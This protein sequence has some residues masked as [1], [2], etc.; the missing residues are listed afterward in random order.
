M[1]VARASHRLS[2][3]TSHN[4]HRFS[5]AEFFDNLEFTAGSLIQAK[6]L[7]TVGLMPVSGLQ[8]K[9]LP[10]DGI[11]T[12]SQFAQVFRVKLAD[13]AEGKD[14]PENRKPL[15]RYHQALVDMPQ[16][17]KRISHFLNRNIKPENPANDPNY[18]SQGEVN[19]APSEG[20]LLSSQILKKRGQRG[21]YRLPSNRLSQ[22]RFTQIIGP[23]VETPSPYDLIRRNSQIHV[24]SI[25]R[26]VN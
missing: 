12:S 6:A 15:S 18:P 16:Q 2:F 24:E 14:T 7:S 19:G 1:P 8:D 25:L 5:K 10:W 4:F 21:F 17:R 22:Q 26:N 20:L 3:A 9:L 23:A 11:P 13:E